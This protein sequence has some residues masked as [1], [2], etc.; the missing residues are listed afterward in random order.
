M[1]KIGYTIIQAADATGV[2]VREIEVA[3]RG[4]QLK[5]HR[6]DGQAVMLKDDITAWLRSFPKWT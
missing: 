5:A 1:S 6:V 3:V 4:K 2:T